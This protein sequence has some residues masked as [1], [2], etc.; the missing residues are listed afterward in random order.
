MICMFMIREAYGSALGYMKC[1]IVDGCV[2]PNAHLTLCGT[3][4]SA[5]P[6]YM[7]VG[8]NMCDICVSVC[9]TIHICI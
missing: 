5:G 2:V 4:G 7:P 9:N 3:F 6:L 1:R 8:H